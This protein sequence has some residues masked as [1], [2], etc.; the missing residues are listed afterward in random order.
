M[1]K[2][3]GNIC[4]H[5]TGVIGSPARQNYETSLYPIRSSGQRLALH[6]AASCSHVD[7]WAEKRI[8]PIAAAHPPPLSKQH[9]GCSADLGHFTVFTAF[10]WKN[11]TRQRRGVV[12]TLTLLDRLDRLETGRLFGWQ[13]LPGHCKTSYV[14]YIYTHASLM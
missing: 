2:L 5:W 9:K 11:S 6:T 13:F 3:C 12:W 4:L 7:P 14:I 8:G 1:R 10:F